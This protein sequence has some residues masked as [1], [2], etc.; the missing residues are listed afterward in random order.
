MQ[1]A[2]VGVWQASKQASKQ[3]DIERLAGVSLETKKVDKTTNKTGTSRE[4]KE[5]RVGTK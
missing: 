3:M 2:E 1:M 4:R 5:L